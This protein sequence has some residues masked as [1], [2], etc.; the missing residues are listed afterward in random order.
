MGVESEVRESGK[1]HQLSQNWHAHSS[2]AAGPLSASKAL[3]HCTLLLINPQG[4]HCCEKWVQLCLLNNSE[5]TQAKPFSRIPMSQLHLMGDIRQLF[6]IQKF[7]TYLDL[8]LPARGYIRWRA[9]LFRFGAS[10]KLMRRID[11]HSFTQSVRPS[12]SRSHR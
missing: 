9:S 4:T 10:L 11:R 1:S 5:N 7:V 2:T 8:S 3:S 12:R 6:Y